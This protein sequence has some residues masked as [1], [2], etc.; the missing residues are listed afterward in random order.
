[1]FQLQKNVPLPAR[2]AVYPFSEMTEGDSFFIADKDAAR[3]ARNAS[4]VYGKKNG[5]RFAIRKV[6]EDGTEG[7]RLWHAG[8]R[9]EGDAGVDD[10]DADLGDI[11]TTDAE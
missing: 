8:A 2:R 11:D 9:P 3:K 5:V 6:T 10:G 4:Y 1:M 7:F